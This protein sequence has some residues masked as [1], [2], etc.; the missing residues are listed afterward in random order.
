M[1]EVRCR[2]WAVVDTTTGEIMETPDGV[3]LSRSQRDAEAEVIVWGPAQGWDADRHR[4][5]PVD[6]KVEIPG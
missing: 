3:T 1:R 2:M 4:V 5:L 6:T